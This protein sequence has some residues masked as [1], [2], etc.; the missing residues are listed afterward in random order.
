[1]ASPPNELETSILQRMAETNSAL[2]EVLTQLRV[3]CREL[4][5]AGSYTYFSPTDPI[6]LPD[7]YVAL[8]ALIS[9]PGVADGMGAILA[10]AN[11]QAEHLELYT[12]GEVLWS[13]DSTGFAIDS[14]GA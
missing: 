9:I 13:G 10:I 4:T 1:M 2:R 3:S 5:G 12:Y 6:P 11:G 14:G 8:D 7:G